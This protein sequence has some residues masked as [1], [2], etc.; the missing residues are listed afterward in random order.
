MI[1]GACAISIEF[2][3]EQGKFSHEKIEELFK[4]WNIPKN[5]MFIGSPGDKFP[6]RI[7]ELGDVRLII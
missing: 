1:T 2:I 6:Y 5:F 4:T 3:E 7:E